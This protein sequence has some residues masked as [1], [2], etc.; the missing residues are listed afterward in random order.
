MP[1]HSDEPDAPD[2]SHEYDQE[3]LAGTTP[4]TALGVCAL[5]EGGAKLTHIR[6]LLEWRGLCECVRL[7]KAGLS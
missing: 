6:L 5:G 2:V 3:F 4:S 7:V 1:R